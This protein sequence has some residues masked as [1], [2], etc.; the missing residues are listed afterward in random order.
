[1]DLTAISI[2]EA[3]KTFLLDEIF[4]CGGGAHNKYLLERI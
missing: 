2:S 1:V 4:V 3:I